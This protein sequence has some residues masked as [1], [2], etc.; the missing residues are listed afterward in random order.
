MRPTPLVIDLESLWKVV[1]VLLESTQNT[2]SR[3]FDGVN[4]APALKK[5]NVGIAV[6][7]A[8]DVSQSAAAIVLTSPVSYRGSH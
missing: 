4:D 3:L 8:T 5:A 7:G 2:S 6:E 1:T